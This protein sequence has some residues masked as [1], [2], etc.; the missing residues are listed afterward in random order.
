L[1]AALAALTQQ[2]LDPT[3]LQRHLASCDAL[4]QYE[5]DASYTSNPVLDNAISATCYCLEGAIN[6]EPEAFV[7][8][9][10]QAHEAVDYLAH[11]ALHAD[12]NDSEQMAKVE[13]H[14]LVVGEVEAQSADLECL[15]SRDLDLGNFA[16]AIRETAGLA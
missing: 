10:M 9:A 2:D 16:L 14:P 7:W 15:A 4:S 12:F 11:T 3:A 5:D 8:A 1:R 6:E 13:I